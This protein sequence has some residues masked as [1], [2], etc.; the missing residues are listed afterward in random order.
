[1]NE[2]NNNK[3]AEETP[4][5]ALAEEEVQPAEDVTQADSATEETQAAP[6]E[7]PAL[8]E[9][10]A[11]AEDFKRKWY[12]VTAEYE[13]YRRRTAGESARRYKEGRADVVSKLFPIGDNLDRALQ[14]C[15]SEATKKGIEMVKKAFEKV[16]EEEHI[17]AIDPLGQPFDAEKHEAI[18]AVDPAEG[19]ES[20]TV[21]SV[22]LKGYEQ[23][24]KVL[25]FAQVV[26]VK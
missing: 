3:T 14:S 19:E 22:Y 7:D 18:M 12:S 25:R 24:G 6:A 2:K 9:A 15:D 20:G 16:L 17:S 1:M 11:Q 8:T 10:R 5:T 13:N 21:K 26:V 4:D 23:D